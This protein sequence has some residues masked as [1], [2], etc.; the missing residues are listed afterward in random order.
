MIDLA[1]RSK[2]FKNI[3]AHIV[4][5]ND[6]FEYEFGLNPVLKHKPARSNRGKPI[7]YY[8]VFNLVNG[9]YGFEVMSHDDVLQHGKKFSKT[10]N[11]GPWQTDFDSMAL[12]TVLK[13]ALK[14]APLKSDFALAVET[15][16][17]IKS[18]ISDDMTRVPSDTLEADYEEK[19]ELQPQSQQVI[20]QQP[21]NPI[22]QDMFQQMNEQII[23]PMEMM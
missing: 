7:F 15:D 21:V 4:Y 13:K 23:D 16:E 20:E 8:A 18:S 5:E 14:Y 3:S 10:F 17:T 2:E 11:K 9:G 19:E 22:E 1:Y 6:E 12:K